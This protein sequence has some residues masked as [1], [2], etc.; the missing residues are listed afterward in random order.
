M[1]ICGGN[2]VYHLAQARC[3]VRV[4]LEHIALDCVQMAVSMHIFV[5]LTA[6]LECFLK[7]LDLVLFFN[8]SFAH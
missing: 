7:N 3:S 1:V 8:L 6:Y 4:I 5:C 2:A